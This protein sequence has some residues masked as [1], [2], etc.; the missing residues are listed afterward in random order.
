[1]SDGLDYSVRLDAISRG[2]DGES[3]WSHAR[4]GAIPGDEPVVV[5]TMQKTLRSGSDIFFALSEMR[6]DDFGE[7]WSGPVE[8]TET[9][10]RR[11]EPNGV[12]VCMC[13]FTPAWHAASGVLLGTGHTAR[14][15]GDALLG[16]PRPRETAY[17]VYDAAARSWSPWET[18]A[19]PDGERFF[20]AGAGSTQ[21][22]DLADGTILLPIYFKGR[23]TRVYATTVMRC[24]F[25][26]RTLTYLEHGDELYIPVPRGLCEPSLTQ[27]DDRFFLTIRNDEQGY[28]TSGPDGLHF[29]EPRPWTFDDGSDLGNYNTQQHWVTHSD[30]LFLVYTR[31]G[32]DNAHVFRHRAPLFIA[33]L[34]PDRLCVLRDT[35]GVLVPERGARLGNFGAC[36]ASERETWVVVS[37]WMQPVGCEK[38]G[39]DNS[40]FVARIVWDRP[41]EAAAW[42]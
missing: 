39:S 16:D 33:R 22:V 7:T 11:P 9:L 5:V 8:H 20:S 29:D 25:D 4:A 34:D 1:M 38:H 21:R 36:N 35:E 32:A 27:L 28:V 41:N 2:F 17:S 19:M 31:R 37:E 13:D 6:T 3:F 30:G 18:M 14:Y 12:E 10:S 24:A 26:G 15:Q 40:V 23:D 42:A